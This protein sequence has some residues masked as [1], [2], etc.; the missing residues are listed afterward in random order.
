MTERAGTTHTVRRNLANALRWQAHDKM[1]LPEHTLM[2]EAADEIDRLNAIV[3]DYAEAVG[4]S[5]PT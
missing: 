3:D 2:L 4:R 1:I 5:A